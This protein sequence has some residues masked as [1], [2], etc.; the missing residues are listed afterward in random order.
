MI[1]IVLRAIWGLLLPGRFKNAIGRALG[2]SIDPSA[3]I[4]PVVL[5]RVGTLVLD[6]DSSIGPFNVLRDLEAI[7]LGSG[8]LIGQWNWISAARE[9]AG[10]SAAA[11]SLR[12]GQEAALT[13][14]H[15]IDCS[16]GVTVERFATVA[17]AR[18][19]I[20]THGIDVAT[21][22]Q[23]AASVTIGEFSIVGSNSKLVPGS[24]VPRFSMVAMGSVVAKGL[25]AEHT[26]YAGT[27]AR[28]V[29]P[30]DSSSLYFHRQRG[31]VSV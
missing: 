9:F 16:G 6:R 10:S 3:R 8:A 15:Y 28:S 13:S 7:E 31:A 4:G 17:G 5:L 20:I 23:R 1:V 19:T 2:Y 14:R 27:P 25:D 18:T 21:S 26:L 24:V 22:R 29:R 11:A 12:V 30:I